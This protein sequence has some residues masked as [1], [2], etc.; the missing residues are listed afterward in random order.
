MMPARVTPGAICLSSSSHFDPV[1]ASNILD[2]VRLPPGRARLATKPLATGSCICVNT[3]GMVRVSRCNVVRVSE[4][5]ATMITSGFSATSST[6]KAC[7]RGG[8]AGGGAIID[9]DVAAFRPP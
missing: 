5:A 7:A 8:V 3:I 9:F 4:T 6:P 1:V 2:P